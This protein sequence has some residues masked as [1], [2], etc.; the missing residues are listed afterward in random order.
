MLAHSISQYFTIAVYPD[1]Y[2][3]RLRVHTPAVRAITYPNFKNT[4]HEPDRHNAYL[5]VWRAMFEFQSS[6]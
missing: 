2:P 1:V 5:D 3:W 4:V 6:E